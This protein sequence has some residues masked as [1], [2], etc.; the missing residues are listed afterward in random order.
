MTDATPKILDTLCAKYGQKMAQ[1]NKDIVERLVTKALAVLQEQGVYALALF[2]LSRKG[3]EKNVGK[4]ILSELRKL[5][6]ESYNNLFPIN[7]P[8][9]NLKFFLER[10]VNDLDTMLL[11]KDLFEQTLIYAR[12]SAKAGG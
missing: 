5:L 3:D 12:F 10:V 8:S 4:Q 2:L 1:N 7:K 6:N 9:D 11:V